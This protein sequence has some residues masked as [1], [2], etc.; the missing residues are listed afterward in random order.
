MIRKIERI[1]Y[2]VRDSKGRVKTTTSPY[3]DYKKKLQ[4]VF[5]KLRNNEVFGAPY[6][7]HVAK[8]LDLMLREKQSIDAR[9]RFTKRAKQ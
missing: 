3:S 7:R 2:E 4:P 5:E 9:Q 8:H 1:V 6:D